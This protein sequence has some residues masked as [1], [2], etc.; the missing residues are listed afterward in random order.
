M[1]LGHGAP[2]RPCA[3]DHERWL[4]LFISDIMPISRRVSA[5]VCLSKNIS[6]LPSANSL[7]TGRSIDQRQLGPRPA[8]LVKPILVDSEACKGC[9][10]T[11]VPTLLKRTELAGAG[12]GSLHMIVNDNGKMIAES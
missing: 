3:P 10:L 4:L 12:C 8:G 5:C 11:S 6:C 1:S 7:R 9:A 2:R